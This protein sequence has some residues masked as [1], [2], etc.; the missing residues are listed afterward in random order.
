MAEPRV[1]PHSPAVVIAAAAATGGAYLAA[2][3][4]HPRGGA[5]AVWPAAA[6]GGPAGSGGLDVV[7]RPVGAE[8]TGHPGAAGCGGKGLPPLFRRGE[9][10]R[11]GLV[12]LG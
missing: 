3:A 10:G 4:V 12:L 9:L 2:P 5:A 8:L 11:G 6:A 1:S 7:S